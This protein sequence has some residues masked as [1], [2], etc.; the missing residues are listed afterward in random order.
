[1]LLQGQ[2]LLSFRSTFIGLIPLVTLDSLFYLQFVLS[3]V[4]FQPLS[5]CSPFIYLV[6]KV[7]RVVLD[8][9]AA[10]FSFLLGFRLMLIGLD[11]L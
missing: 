1:M 2:L 6:L 3:Y 4:K 7:I 11:I 8:A 5:S 10:S 9:D